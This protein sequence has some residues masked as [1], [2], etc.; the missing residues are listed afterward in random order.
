MN[1]NKLMRASLIGVMGLLTSM[2]QAQNTIVTNNWNVTP[3]NVTGPTLQAFE[4]MPSW[5][6]GTGNTNNGAMGNRSDRFWTNEVA[7]LK[8][9]IFSTSGIT[10]TFSG[11]KIQPGVPIFVD[12]RCKIYPFASTPPTVASNTVLSFYSDS[13][14]NLVV[15]SYTSTVTCKTNINITIL[16]NVYYSVMIRFAADSFDVFFDNSTTNVLSLNAATNQISKM[17]ISGD[18]E[19]DDLY[20]SYG[21]PRRSTTNYFFTGWTPSTPEESVVASWVASQAATN[22]A[23]VGQTITSANA[24]NYYLT[25]TALSA[26]D[27]T[28]QLGI[29]SINYNPSSTSVTVV[30]TL[31]TDGNTKKSG[32]INGVL[33]LKGAATYAAATSGTW[34][35]VLNTVKIGSD[36]F[37]NGLAT[38]TFTLPD[39]TYKFFLPVIQSNIQ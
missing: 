29:G 2:V 31:K 5:A 22:S 33:K 36:D 38:Y 20:I 21:D 32:K 18:G 19:L 13:K 37:N 26:N 6:I 12:M 15:A 1:I 8:S 34:S 23:L 4:T 9:L 27:F 39:T 24:I 16:T 11:A 3:W 35:G 30:V 17:V 7:S 25:D 10:N 28:G 14:S